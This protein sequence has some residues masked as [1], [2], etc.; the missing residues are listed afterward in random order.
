MAAVTGTRR[1]RRV[2]A[3]GLALA[4]MA[5][6][7]AFGYWVGKPG[8]LDF[9]GGA[10]RA[11]AP[12]PVSA[13]A[14]TATGPSGTTGSAGGSASGDPLPN[15]ALPEPPPIDPELGYRV[16]GYTPH[17]IGLPFVTRNEVTDRTLEL[18][19][20]GALVYRLEQGG[21]PVYQPVTTLQWA[22]GA[23]T[24]Y[25][26]TGQSLWLDLARA[27]AAKTLAGKIESDGA[28][29]YPYR[30][31]WKSDAPHF[32][33]QPPWY[34]GM[35][36]GE[37]LSV[38]TQ[39]AREFPDQPQWREAADRTFESF[40]QPVSADQPWMTDVVDGF[41]WFEEYVDPD[42]FQVLNGH[43]FALF[44][45][46]E[47]AQL[48][49]DQRALDLFD[50]GATTALHAM[51]TIRVPGETSLYCVELERCVEQKWQHGDYQKIHIAQLGM[52]EAM[53]GD[54]AFGRWAEAL[55][56][57]VDY[58]PWRVAELWPK[59]R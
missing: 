25:W 54:P 23:H 11:T 50:G 6:S 5:A 47:Y 40:L 2:A 10:G 7:A 49:G 21:E 28:Y 8:G 14:Q 39:M 3:A 12:P 45:L 31:E 29:Y 58:T 48:T 9:F 56:S 46:Y 15:P 24:Q 18:D 38:F 52:L 1:R 42:P 55:A 34:S 44:G 27:S 16:S 4:A 19:G 13:G 41:V 32:D 33:F 36:Q 22:I 30:Y 20:D 26:L 43:I 17:D 57:D 59:A 51:E 37:A 35:A 53:T